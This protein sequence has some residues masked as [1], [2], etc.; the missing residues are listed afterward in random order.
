MTAI[1]SVGVVC[2]VLAIATACG[3]PSTEAPASSARLTLDTYAA[4]RDRIRPSDAESAWEEIDWRVSY[5]DG[6]R[7]AS[8]QGKPV[9]LWVMNGH[10]LGC[11]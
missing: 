9:L 8:T 3:D 7:E 6:L 10:P 4:Y 5:A 1:R 2:W 11:T